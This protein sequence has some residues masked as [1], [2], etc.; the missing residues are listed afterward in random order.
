[1]LT[2]E[3]MTRIW[4]EVWDSETMF[5]T[6]FD[7]EQQLRA[8]AK[9]MRSN[10]YHLQAI[11]PEAALLRDLQKQELLPKFPFHMHETVYCLHNEQ[12]RECTIDRYYK[13]GNE[14]MIALDGVEDIP[15]RFSKD[16]LFSTHESALERLEYLRDRK[17][18]MTYIV[19]CHIGDTLYCVY[20]G[21]FDE[22]YQVIPFTVSEIVIEENSTF[23]KA[24]HSSLKL[25]IKD[26]GETI[27][28]TPEEAEEALL[29]KNAQIPIIQR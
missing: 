24:K 9:N 19:P 2:V 13:Q 7:N 8:F 27:F 18:P 10:T 12:I 23:L 17:K 22:S 28:Y 14:W 6:N 26:F 1:M 4:N 11:K 29:E 5:Q 15:L 20:K 16:K 3:E 25:P 21:T